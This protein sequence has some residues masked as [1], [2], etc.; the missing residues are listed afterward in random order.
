MPFQ[1]N[2]IDNDGRPT[3]ACGSKEPAERLDRCARRHEY[4]V[5][6]SPMRKQG[7]ASLNLAQ[8]LRACQRMTA[9]A[10]RDPAWLAPR[11]KV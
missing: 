1:V 2:R 8:K 6:R 3:A 4:P 10:E 9:V 7:L 5:C 11:Q